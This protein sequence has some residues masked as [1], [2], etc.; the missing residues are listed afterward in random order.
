MMTLDQVASSQYGLV[1]RQQAVDLLGA[2]EVRREQRRGHLI[3]VHRGVFR[4]L[5]APG[6]FR[7]RALAAH[8]AYGP[9][10][11]VSHG[12]AAVLWGLDGVALPATID[13]TVPPTRS[14]RRVGV[15]SHRRP[16][17]DVDVACRH[18]V[19]VTSLAVTLLDLSTMVDRALL[20]RCVDEAVRRH[21]RDPVDLLEEVEGCP[22]H[23]P[24]R[25]ALRSV[26]RDRARRGVGDSPGVDRV[27][28][29]MAAAGLP[30]PE[31]DYP[32]VVG[33]RQRFVDAA[34]PQLKVAIEFNGWEFHQM[35]SR[36]D[37]DHART[38]ELELAGWVVLVVT[39]AHGEAD[40]ID[41]IRRA[42]EL[43]SERLESEDTRRQVIL[44]KENIAIARASLAGGDGPLS[45]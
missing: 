32:V 12:A 28:G 1:T 4:C 40:T 39:A 15:R 42:L 31:C 14:A 21:R 44:W 35:R 29:W 18:L 3:T 30:A 38:S 19:P 20:G 9:P 13:V 8:L 25:Q 37:E 36:A 24:A 34:Y 7:Q 16:L 45:G 6:S 41:R 17:R 43:Q 23:R 22:A 10:A 5:G 26:L 11:F 27:L 2:D 33:G